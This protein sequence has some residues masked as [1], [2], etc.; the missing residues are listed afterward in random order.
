[1]KKTELAKED[2]Y[3]GFLVLVNPWHPLRF[4]YRAQLV[5]ADGRFP[6]VCLQRDAAEA[7]QAALREIGAGDAIVPV[8]GYRT[9]EEQTSIY[10]GCLRDDGEEFT[11]KYVALPDHSEHQVGLAIDLGLRKEEIDFIRPDFP[12][13]GIC[14]TFRK[15]APDFGFIERYP[16]GKEAVTGTGHEPWHFRYVGFPHSRIIA[17]RGLTLEEYTE[18]IKDYREKN[19]LFYSGSRAGSCVGAEGETMICYVPAAE[20]AGGAVSAAA[21]DGAAYRISGNN[22]DGFILTVWGHGNGT[23]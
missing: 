22:V 4:D 14:Q 18:F 15:T 5:P 20:A 10:N 6:H 9:L 16:A 1:M 8:S 11:K 3:R 12:Y 7:L 13:D 2:M 21:L 17:D 23:R 19:P